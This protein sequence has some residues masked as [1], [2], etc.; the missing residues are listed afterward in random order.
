MA[1]AEE[2]AVGTQTRLATSLIQQVDFKGLAYV[3]VKSSRTL[4]DVLASYRKIQ[5]QPLLEVKKT[6]SSFNFCL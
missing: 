2:S 5:A 4:S 3:Q 6:F 1:I